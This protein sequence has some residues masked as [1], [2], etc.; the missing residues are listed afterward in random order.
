MRQ[1]EGFNIFF[2][3]KSKRALPLDLEYSK[4]L[5]VLKPT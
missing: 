1:E 5:S 4:R 3:T 2:D